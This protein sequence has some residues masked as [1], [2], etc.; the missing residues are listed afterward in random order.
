M[1]E[2]HSQMKKYHSET[3]QSVVSHYPFQNHWRALIQVQLLVQSTVVIWEVDW[4]F[5]HSVKP[6]SIIQC[7]ISWQVQPL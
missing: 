3:A 6:K 7:L 2:S 4:L 5:W 1:F